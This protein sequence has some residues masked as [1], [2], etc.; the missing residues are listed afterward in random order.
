MRDQDH[1]LPEWANLLLREEHQPS[2]A[3]RD[4]IMKRVRSLPAPRVVAAPVQRTH[5]I[6]RGLLTPA[7]SAAASLFLLVVIVFRIGGQFVLGANFD[8]S[9]RVVGD[10]IV[11][12]IVAANHGG[13]LH[14]TLY[15]TMRVVEFAV[16]GESVRSAAVAGDF[17]G[18]HPTSLQRT[19]YSNRWSARVVVPRDALQF[20]YIVNDQQLPASPVPAAHATVPDSI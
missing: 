18:W 8:R 15:D 9:V 6:R 5:W 13:A 12:R 20:E 1:C 7:G 3:S 19:G 10:T 2:A 17:N 11:Q 4:L 16:R 14:D